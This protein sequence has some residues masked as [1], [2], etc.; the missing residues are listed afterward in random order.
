MITV[1][2]LLNA[3]VV[4]STVFLKEEISTY[5][6]GDLTYSNSLK[7][8]IYSA[9]PQICI[10]YL[11]HTHEFS[12][13]ISSWPPLRC[14][15]HISNL[16]QT[17]LLFS[18][19]NPFLLHHISANGNSIL[20]TFSLTLCNSPLAHSFDLNINIQYIQIWLLTFSTTKTLIQLT[21]ISWI[22]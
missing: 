4:H 9:D 13:I 12:V 5:S 6:L 3:G 11:E 7:T 20:L 22:E 18:L 15:I 16:P 8:F 10:S 17:E 14:L 21:I 2:K 1:F 19:W